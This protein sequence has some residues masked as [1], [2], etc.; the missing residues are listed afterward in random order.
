PLIISAPGS[1]AKG[2][3]T[4][5]LAELIDMYPTLADL[6]G[7]KAPANLQGQSLRP[8]LDDPNAPGKKGAYTQVMRGGPKA[9]QQF[10]ARSVRTGRWRYTEWDEGRKGVEL[11]DHDNDPHEL[12]NLAREEKYA[13]TV[14]S[15]RQLLHAPVKAGAR[16]GAAAPRA[17]GQKP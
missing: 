4:G 10:L 11:Y 6:C 15:L 12:K 5:R 3:T 16:T 13:K 9:K 17:A 1:K 2:K 8:Q 14:A 7:L